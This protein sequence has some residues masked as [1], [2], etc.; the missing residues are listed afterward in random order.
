MKKTKILLTTGLCLLAS[1]FT[2]CQHVKDFKE[3]N[4]VAYDMLADTAKTVLL[5]QVPRITD[6]QLYQTSLNTVIEAAF[7]AADKPDAVA[8]E[9]ETGVADVFPDDPELQ[10]MVA[11]EFAHAL[12][13]ADQGDAP[14]SSP[15]ARQY[16][17]ELAD[18]LAPRSTGVSPVSRIDTER[19]EQIQRLLLVYHAPVSAARQAEVDALCAEIDAREPAVPGSAAGGHWSDPVWSA[20]EWF[21]GVDSMAGFKA[22]HS[23]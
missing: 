22:F 1:V 17:L 5:A 3:D 13:D 23:Y 14:A 20:T 8:A 7:Q 10:E 15:G 9:I 21:S 6:D 18:A 11:A 16:Q 19:D 4:P 12:R 2:G